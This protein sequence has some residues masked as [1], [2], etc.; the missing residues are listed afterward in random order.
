MRETPDTAVDLVLQSELDE[1]MRKLA[2]SQNE[3]KER[4]YAGIAGIVGSCLAALVGGVMFLWRE[5]AGGWLFVLGGLLG[6]ILSV[7]AMAAQP[8]SQGAAD[9]LL[10]E[11][12]RKLTGEEDLHIDPAHRTALHKRLTNDATPEVAVAALKLLAIMG[13]QESLWYVEG[14]A[15]TASQAH[16]FPASLDWNV[17][18]LAVQSAARLHARIE[19]ARLATTLL[20]PAGVQEDQ[21]LRPSNAEGLHHEP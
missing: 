7:C 3:K 9:L 14:L 16:L 21:L 12:A 10:Y 13:N 5:Q 8:P 19:V 15:G 18:Q 4:A 6:L 11:L 17:R 2:W 1:A 20:R